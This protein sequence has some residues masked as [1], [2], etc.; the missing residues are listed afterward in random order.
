[1]K[2]I[3]SVPVALCAVLL[4]ILAMQAHAQVFKCQMPNGRIE[5][6]NH[7]CEG[8]GQALIPGSSA[9]K[10]PAPAARG[11]DSEGTEAT[12]RRLENIRA[13]NAGQAPRAVAGSQGYKGGPRQG[14]PTDQ[15]IRNM[16]VSLSSKSL[17]K[18][19]RE[20]IEEEI[21]RARAAQAGDGSYSQQDRDQLNYLRSRQQNAVRHEEREAARREADEIH[22]RAGSQSAADGIAARRAMEERERQERLER[23]NAAQ[24]GG[25]VLCTNTGCTDTLGRRYEPQGGF[26]QRSDGRMCTRSGNFVHC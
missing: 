23:Q 16:E 12:L 4:S 15:D 21:R 8:S 25:P 20:H 2:L 6:R 24:S 18:K 17:S 22:L 14:A 13:G 3:R 19:E 7:A 11:S 10:R 5:Y 1:M 26:M 9:P